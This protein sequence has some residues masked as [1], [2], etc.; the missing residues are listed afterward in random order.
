MINRPDYIEALE[1]FI[2]KPLVKI[3]A[4][5]RRCGKSTIF[6]ML[7]EEF[8]RRGVSM[9]HIICKRYTEMDIPE[10]ITA[11]QMY[12]ELTAAMLGKGHCYLLLDEIQEIDGWEKA[13]NSLLE[14]TDADIYVTGSNSKLMSG[15]IS[16]YLT[17]RYVSIPV[18]TLSFKEYLAF[19]QDSPLS[20]R[21]L[22]ED[23]IRFGGF[24]L[25]ALSEY[26]EQSAYQIVNGIYHTVVSRDIVKRHRINKQD[27]FDRVV[28]YII[29]NMGKTFS[30]NSISTFLK[31]E[32]RKVSVESIYNYL[33]WLEQAFIIYPCH[34]YD[35]QGKA[36]LATQE[37]YY[38]ADVTLKYCLLGYDRKMLDGALENIVFLELKRRGYEVYIGKN[39]AK[40]IDFIGIRRDEKIYVQVCVQ[41]PE[42]SDR[43]IG[44]LME[45][46]DHYPKYVVT[47]NSLDVGNE[48][49]IRIVHLADFLLDEQW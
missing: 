14:S 41:L 1:P 47:T 40:E 45:I 19:K 17:G 4:G 46:Q 34:R 5:V 39:A 32:H 28:K 22:L 35:I 24:P 30:A 7:K 16:T 20:R 43:E 36:V 37:K 26:D 6:E 11:K 10:S 9:D 33:R 27:L 23:Y 49:G 18:Y 31:S 44:N 8:L 2:D 42:N 21:E 29:E 13:V 38:L 25:V 3:L 15:E 12:D 48:N